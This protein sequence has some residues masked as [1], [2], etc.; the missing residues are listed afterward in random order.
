MKNIRLTIHCNWTSS[1][2]LE[3]VHFNIEMRHFVVFNSKSLLR[4]FLF[5]HLLNFE[6]NPSPYKGFCVPERWFH[7][8]IKPLRI[9]L[10]T[11]VSFKFFNPEL[12]LSDWPLE[13]SIVSFLNA[14][15]QISAEI[16]IWITEKSKSFLIRKNLFQIRC[17]I[18]Y[19][20]MIYWQS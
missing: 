3:S 19:L 5:L 9:Y 6:L 12:L 11:K 2:E 8:C 4:I 1:F 14:F 16:K 20:N 7:R 15:E 17:S 18:W 10:K 13:H